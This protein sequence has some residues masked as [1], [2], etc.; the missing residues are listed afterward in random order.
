VVGGAYNAAADAAGAPGESRR[1][2]D[3]LRRAGFVSG[4]GTQQPFNALT[5]MIGV[6]TGDGAG[7]P[8]MLNAG[9]GFVG[10]IM[11]SAN[12]P[13]KIAIAVDTQMDDGVS[14]LGTVRGLVQGAPN[15]PI[16]VAQVATPT[17]AETSTNIYVLC[18]AL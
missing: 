14:G 5:G 10:L 18:R 2:W 13:D 17:Y 11:C 9:A 16:G 12:L 7:G 4:T 15:P 1:W 8:T 3:H 6:Q